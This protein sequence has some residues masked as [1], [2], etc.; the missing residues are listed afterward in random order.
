MH[1]WQ[2]LLLIVYLSVKWLGLLDLKVSDTVQKETI[3]NY[4]FIVTSHTS[5]ICSFGT[6]CFSLSEGPTISLIHVCM[7]PSLTFLALLLFKIY[8]GDSLVK[9]QLQF[10]Y[11]LV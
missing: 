6:Y 8:V 1:V 5:G 7:L 2:L 3:L 11:Y 10:L 4:K 9:Y